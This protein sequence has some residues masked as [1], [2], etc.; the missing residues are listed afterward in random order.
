MRN[1]IERKAVDDEG[2]NR[3]VVLST[4]AHDVVL[5]RNGDNREFCRIANA[6]FLQEVMFSNP[7]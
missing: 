4:F 6:V 7:S 3:A 2:L 1:V 5:P